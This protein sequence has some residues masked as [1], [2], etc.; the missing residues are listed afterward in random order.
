MAALRAG[1]FLT[2][3]E[4]NASELPL[5][6]VNSSLRAPLSRSRALPGQVGLTGT[7][8]ENLA[9]RALT[10]QSDLPSCWLVGCPGAAQPQGVISRYC[11]KGQLV[12]LSSCT[13]N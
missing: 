7:L 4:Q 12:S 2:P 1:G 13:Q 5:R 6:F 9:A 8:R 11:K 10:Q 3:L